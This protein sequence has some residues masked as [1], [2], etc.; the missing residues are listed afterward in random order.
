GWDE[1]LQH[2]N[3]FL[4]LMGSSI[5]MM[6]RSALAYRSPLYG[7]RT[8]QL[9]LE[10]LEFKES[11]KFFP[12]RNM[13]E[14]IEFYSVLGGTPAY[15]LQFSDKRSLL[16]NIRERALRRD[17]FLYNEVEFVLREELKEPRQYFTILK[18]MAFG[19]TKVNEISLAAGLERNV[20][21]RYLSI[22]KGLRIIRREIPIT[23]KHPH[24]SRK[25]IY[26]IEDNYFRFWFEFVFPNRSH[27]EKDEIDFVTRKIDQQLSRFVSHSFEEIC[28][29]LLWQ[30]L[31]Q[32]KSPF[33]FTRIGR[34]WHKDNEIDI[35]AL[36]EETKE[37]M[38]AECKWQDRKVGREVIENLLDKSELVEWNR[39]DR[40]V[41]FALFSKAGFNK[42]CMDL[43]EENGILTYDLK[44]ID[45]IL[46]G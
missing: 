38:F 41:H 4:I 5:S 44:D 43:C 7:R 35:V 45:R 23:E 34:W 37:I 17:A 12:K 28:Q 11:R 8:G 14:Q 16:D 6:E 13:K 2:A 10:P 46:R 21:S 18:E 27:I 9:L 20:L 40:N 33:I 36:N 22:L 3:I 26:K 19:K 25:G 31:K 42:S 39:A 30:L 32:R 29:Q 1:Y 15:L 24:K